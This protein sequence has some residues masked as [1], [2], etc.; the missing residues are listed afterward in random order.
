MGGSPR[1]PPGHNAVKGTLWHTLS[2]AGHPWTS[3]EAAW[4]RCRISE[5][6]SWASKKFRKIQQASLVTPG[7]SRVAVAAKESCL[8]AARGVTAKIPPLCSNSLWGGA[9]PFQDC[10]A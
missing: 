9:T 1:T 10:P 7:D 6:A 5:G 2:S 4:G 8:Q 3:K